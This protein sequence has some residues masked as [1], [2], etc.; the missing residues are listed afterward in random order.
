MGRQGVEDLLIP[1]L[2]QIW[3]S[4]SMFSY[5]NTHEK[6]REWNR[7]H[8]KIP[9]TI[10][11]LRNMNQ[12][13]NQISIQ[14]TQKEASNSKSQHGCGAEGTLTHFPSGIWNCTAPAKT[15]TKQFDMYT[16]C[17][18]SRSHSYTVTPVKQKL[19]SP[20]NLSVWAGGGWLRD[21]G[22]QFPAPIWQLRTGSN[23]SFRG[24]DTH[25]D[26]CMSAKYQ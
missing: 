9:I 14:K 21:P 3:Y 15:K 20:W 23:S 7:A 6:R 11:H 12:K 26:I 8:Q 16:D 18:T 24:S 19:M 4:D 13:C 1:D 17:L 5:V 2:I 10:S 25:T 22:V